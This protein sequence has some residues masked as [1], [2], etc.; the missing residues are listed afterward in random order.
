MTDFIDTLIARSFGALETVRPRPATRFE[1]P[2]HGAT[3]AERPDMAEAAASTAA[4]ATPEPGSGLVRPDSDPGANAT[5]Q[6]TYRTR[7]AP[8]PGMLRGREP[9]PE[10]PSGAAATSRGADPLAPAPAVPQQASAPETDLPTPRAE[11]AGAAP[12]SP[13]RV[14]RRRDRHAPDITPATGAP[15][16]APPGRERAGHEEPRTSV[17]T[18]AAREGGFANPQAEELAGMYRSLSRRLDSEA[19]E[20]LPEERAR[21]SSDELVGMLRKHSVGPAPEAWPVGE[22]GRAPDNPPQNGDEL[23]LRP[24]TQSAS[25][26]PNT[27]SMEPKESGIPAERMKTATPTLSR[28]ASFR[29]WSD[30]AEAVQPGPRASQDGRPPDGLTDRLKPRP[31]T[32]VFREE[33]LQTGER[34][35]TVNVTIGSIEMV[36]AS[37]SAPPVR[38]VRAAPKLMSLADYLNQR[39]RGEG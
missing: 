30:G 34:E 33:Q 4:P 27:G 7:A 22:R 13:G 20:R 25:G 31:A 9:A 35:I 5:A 17:Q 2:S 14:S 18:D 36:Q 21:R 6:D 37:S 24:L 16:T 28:K 8:D 1:P 32:P 39:D 3:G 11:T 19:R 29:D 38:R 23:S 15:E 26:D 10:T 12:P